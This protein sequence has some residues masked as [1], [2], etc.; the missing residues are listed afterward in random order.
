M[1]RKEVAVALRCSVNTIYRMTADGR[2]P[3][4]KVA[5]LIRVPR[6]A[7]EALAAGASQ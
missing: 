5:G 1:T 3:T 7:V 6:S 4:V 2:L